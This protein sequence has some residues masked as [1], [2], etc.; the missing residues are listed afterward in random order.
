MLGQ[1]KRVHVNYCIYSSKMLIYSE[2]QLSGNRIHLPLSQY[3]INTINIHNNNVLQP[4]TPLS[5]DCT[6]EVLRQL[7]SQ[8]ILPITSTYV[9]VSTLYPCNSQCEEH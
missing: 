5:T 9:A 7:V 8:Q 3:L 6:M 2:F 1:K 4:L